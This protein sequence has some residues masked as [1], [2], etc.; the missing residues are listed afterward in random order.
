MCYARSVTFGE[1]AS[2]VH[3][4]RPQPAQERDLELMMERH[5]VW[6][7]TG[8]GPQHAMSL[9]ALYAVV[10]LIASTI[11]Q[12]TLT[13]NHG[14]MPNRI[15]DPKAW[16]S[17]L[18]LGD[19]LQ[20]VVTSM[21]TRGAGYLRAL[22]ELD[23]DGVLRWTIDALHPDSVQAVVSARGVVR[24]DY[25]LDGDPI[26]QV[27]TN[28]RDRSAVIEAV[29]GGRQDPHLIACPY[30]VTPEHPE[31]STPIREAWA[32]IEGY[33]QVE[34]QAANLLQGGTYSGGILETD[35]DLT[36]ETARRYQ[37]AWVEATKLGRVK[38]LGGGLRYRSEIISPK[39]ATWLDSRLFDMQSVC[40]LYG[41]PP[42]LVG[43]AQAG[44]GSLSYQNRQDNLRSFRSSALEA[45]TSQI[46][47]AWSAMLPP[48][49]RFIFDYSEWEATADADAQ[50]AQ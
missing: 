6:A 5:I 44:N 9:P 32:S 49:Q 41:V 13:T 33:L 4:V 3:A 47:D 31:G 30:L 24:I 25:L 29:R 12:L 17:A 15:S 23:S 11:D 48:G 14:V 7:E 1:L 42:D 37:S 34:R 39:D 16:G 18:D 2:M 40:A 35:H 43:M 10:R 19:Q 46:A 22:P 28:N 27:P 45:F 36:P 8:T 26:P 38:V 50:P 20:H 21:A